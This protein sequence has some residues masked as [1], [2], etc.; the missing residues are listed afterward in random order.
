[1]RNLYLYKGI[2]AEELAFLDLCNYAALYV[3]PKFNKKTSIVLRVRLDVDIEDVRIK[4]YQ[5]QICLVLEMS[6]NVNL[7]FGCIWNYNSIQYLES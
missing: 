1:L 6:F 3:L 7:L 2:L 4:L 5:Y